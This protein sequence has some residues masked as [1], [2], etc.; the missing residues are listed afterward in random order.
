MKSNPGGPCG[1]AGGGCP[2]RGD[3]ALSEADGE[4]GE[5]PW[6]AGQPRRDGRPAWRWRDWE[7]AADTAPKAFQRG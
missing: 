4:R 7:T 5:E 6:R 1:E 3:P 2:G